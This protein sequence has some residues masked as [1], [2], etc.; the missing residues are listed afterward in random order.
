MIDI[1]IL[2]V[3]VL[4]VVGLGVFYLM[5]ALVVPH[6]L[7]SIKALMESNRYEEAIEALNGFMKN[8]ERNPLAHL[9]LA[10]AYFY[11]GNMEMAMVEY[12]QVLAM[13]KFNKTVTEKVIHKRLAEIFT[14]FGQLEEA[15]KEYVLL[16]RMDPGNYEN[17][18][19]IGKLFFDRG[20]KEQ[21]LAYLD[22]VLKIS[23]NHAPTYFLLGKLYY[24]MNRPNEAL[25]AFNNCLQLDNKNTE[26]HYYLGM[27]LKAMGNFG[28]ALQA[29]D[30]SE[31][32][33]DTNLKVKSIYQKGVCKREMGELESAIADYERALK[34]ASTETNTSIAVRYSLGMAYESQRRLLEAVEQ[35]EKVAHM[36]PNYQEVQA[37]LSQYEDLRIDDR[38]KDLLTA[39]P[40]T[41]EFI[42]QKLVDAMGYEAVESKLVGDDSVQITAVERSQ[43]WR[44]VRGGKV[45][46]MISRANEDIH[47]DEVAKLVEQTKIMHGIRVIIVSTGKFTPQAVRYSENRPVDLYDRQK[48]S[49]VM[50]SMKN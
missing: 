48:L 26:A 9:Y 24:E 13:G 30:E 11:S 25:N 10:E 1:I 14:Q 28:K 49:A 5:K 39:T 35:W 44:N 17:I 31:K 19:Q 15:Q 18:Y 12:R 29:F 3:I 21:S 4:G 23:R 36:R 20:M 46:I 27:I 38:L 42:C 16:S 8:D 22:K 6:Q 32:A 7:D 40:T 41:F 2:G 37:K 33:R 50:K 47:E 34:Y 45:L 43:K